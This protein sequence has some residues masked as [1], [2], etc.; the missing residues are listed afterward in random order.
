MRKHI[1]IAAAA[2]ASLASCTQELPTPT[3]A[4]TS[5][6]FT[7]TIEQTPDT[8]TIL[9]GNDVKWKTG[10]NISINGVTFTADATDPTRATFTKSD[11]QDDPVSPYRAYY[12]ST[13]FDGTTA[14]L[15]AQQTYTEG[16]FSNNPMYATSTSNSLAF[17]NICGVLAIS[18]TSGDIATLKSIRISSSSKNLCGPFTIDDNSNAVLTSADGTSAVEL[19]LPTAQTLTST[20]S[21][22]YIAVP[23]T[24]YPDLTISLSSDGTNYTESLTTKPGA[25]IAISRNTIYC[26][27]SGKYSPVTPSLPTGALPGTFTVN[28]SGS[29]IHFS[30]GNLWLNTAS[31]RIWSFETNQYDYPKSYNVSHLGHFLWTKDITECTIGMPLLERKASDILFTNDP[32]DATKPCSTFTV[33]GTTGQWRALTADEMAYLFNTRPMKYGKPR[34]SYDMNGTEIESVKYTGIFLYPDDYSGEIVSSTMTWADINAAGI[35]FLPNSNYLYNKTTPYL[36]TGTGYHYYWLS[37]KKA[38]TDKPYTLS[39]AKSGFI[40]PNDDQPQDEDYA[41]ALRLVTAETGTQPTNYTINIA[42]PTN[43]TISVS[44][45]YAHEGETVTIT[46]TPDSGYQTET[47]TVTTGDSTPVTCTPDTDDPNTFTFTM[48]ASAVSITVTFQQSS[49]LPTGALPGTFTVNSS[50]K[51]VHFSQGNLYYDGTSWG[52]ESNQ[53]DYRTWPNKAASIEGNTSTSTPSNNVGLFYWNVDWQKA[54]LESYSKDGSG[55]GDLFFANGVISGWVTLSATEWNFLMQRGRVNIWN[56]P[57]PV[58]YATVMGIHGLIL[59]PDMF[60]DPN[61]NNGNNSF[62][63][64]STSP[65]W[66]Q[67]VYSTLEDWSSM[68]NAGA[69]FLPAVGQRNQWNDAQPGSYGKYWFSSSTDATKADIVEFDSSN[70]H[71][72]NPVGRDFAYAIRLVTVAE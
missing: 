10:D 21:T 18:L 53:Y 55:E 31:P 70:V 39:V 62:C 20:A 51:T 65:T 38:S 17:K 50:G 45:L 35:V 25:T 13:I 56:D 67:N 28:T 58:G 54:I 22:F 5:V 32:S 42:T 3:P 48:P 41:F 68:E 47:A 15:P 9:D 66:D 11:T 52:F 40:N 6:I 34:Y 61:K 29:A 46:A 30:Q 27:S 44:P 72:D 57:Y 19:V 60:I 59:L 69:V 71:P 63:K 23:P 8:K 24:T 14:T 12:P 7:A 16:E 1:V 36:N 4:A 49:S 64:F 43:G 37:T 26:I 2:I 33:N